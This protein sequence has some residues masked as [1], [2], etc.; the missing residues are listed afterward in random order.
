MSNQASNQ[1]LSD[2]D[3][4][5]LIRVHDAAPGAYVFG[6][7]VVDCLRELQERRAADGLCPHG[8][9]LAE[10]ICGPCSQG[11]PMRA[12][13]TTD[14]SRD[15]WV[16]WS[17]EGG[18]WIA[19][20]HGARKTCEDIS[21]AISRDIKESGGNRFGLRPVRITAHIGAEKTSVPTAATECAKHGVKLAFPGDECWACAE[22]A[23]T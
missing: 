3:L 7:Q 9:P 16:A 23:A 21:D 11:R 6:R 22:D 13:E 17:D 2:V 1:R 5:E 20:I 19:A 14:E 8:L 18:G 12:V 4:R 10:N 15:L